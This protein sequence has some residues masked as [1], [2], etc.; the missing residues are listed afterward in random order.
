MRAG[1]GPTSAAGSRPSPRSRRASRV[2][3]WWSSRRPQTIAGSRRSTSPDRPSGATRTSPS[4]SLRVSRRADRRQDAEQFL[5]RVAVVVPGSDTDEPDR[6]VQRLVERR[7]LIGRAMV[8]DLHDIDPAEVRGGEQPH[9]RFLAEVA[10]E[11][12]AQAPDGAR[13]HRAHVENDARLV[14]GLDAAW[15]WPDHLP[16][17]LAQHAALPRRHLVD[18]GAAGSER[19]GDPGVAGIRWRADQDAIDVTRRPRR[20]RR[21]GRGRSG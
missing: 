3:P 14:A 8:R 6:R 13:A 10:E 21:H 1:S 12:A 11:D 17:E 20:R 19:F 15:W 4:R 2:P 7:R 9:L 5:G 16:S 18:V